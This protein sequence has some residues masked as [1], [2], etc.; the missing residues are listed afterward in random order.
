RQTANSLPR[1]SQSRPNGGEKTEQPPAACGSAQSSTLPLA[2]FHPTASCGHNRIAKHARIRAA[3][4]LSAA[5]IEN[6]RVVGS[7][8]TFQGERL[9]IRQ[10]ASW[11]HATEAPFL[12]Q[13]IL[14]DRPL[15]PV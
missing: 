8:D 13:R 1:I 12:C 2:S 15:V 10:N 3:G 6:E 4:R 9:R 11:R 14:R 5:D 7:N